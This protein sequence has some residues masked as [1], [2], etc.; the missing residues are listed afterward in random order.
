MQMTEENQTECVTYFWKL[1]LLLERLRDSK[2]NI[3]AQECSHSSI[4]LNKYYDNAAQLPHR[5]FHRKYP[6]S[7]I[8]TI[9]I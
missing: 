2:L 8:S 3:Q 4:S 7:L 6:Q 9:L 5:P 1:L